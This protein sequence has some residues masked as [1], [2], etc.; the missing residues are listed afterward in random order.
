[1]DFLT[2]H[3]AELLQKIAVEKALNDALAAELKAA[4][5]AFKQTWK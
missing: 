2:L 1:M 3:K 4:A 5:D